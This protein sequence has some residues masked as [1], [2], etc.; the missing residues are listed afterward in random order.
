MFAERHVRA[1]RHHRPGG[2]RR[3]DGHHRAEEEQAL[4][5]RG[6]DDDLLEDQLD[7]RRRSAAAGRAGRR[8][9]GP[10]GSGSSRWPCAPTA[11]GRRRSSISGTTSATI[12]TRLQT[13]GQAPPRSTT[14]V[15]GDGVE[16]GA[17][18]APAR[19][20]RRAGGRS[21]L[22]RS[23]SRRR[24]SARGRRCR[25]WPAARAPRRSA[26]RG[27][28]H[29]PAARPAPRPARRE[30][31]A[32][33]AR[34]SC[35]AQLAAAAPTTGGRASAVS[36]S[37]AARRTIG[38][39]GVDRH[40]GDALEAAGRTDGRGRRGRPRRVSATGCRG[41]RRPCA[42]SPSASARTSSEVSNSKPG[43]AEQVAE[44][45]QHLPRRPRLAERLDDAVEAL[46][47]AFGVDEGA[48]GLGERRD[49]QQHV[50]DVA[51]RRWLEGASA[52]PPCSAA[53]RPPTAAAAVRRHRAPARR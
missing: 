7:A 26:Q 13:T 28:E 2:Q 33:S 19:G 37:E 22:D 36:C 44:H 27:V 46:H 14:A 4:V 38:S 21:A 30:P 10:A 8:G 43:E 5:G 50:G 35:G 53:R 23:T 29:A 34:P 45:A 6:R 39:V 47:A 9:S 24:T 16:H 25:R 31:S 18:S 42:T 41:G 32:P 15:A 12:L 40:V 52:R 20:G 1:E 3:H 17:Q 49:R 11:S 48:G 51:R